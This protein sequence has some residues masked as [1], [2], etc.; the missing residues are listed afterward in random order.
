M[1]LSFRTLISGSEEL[2]PAAGEEI[3]DWAQRAALEKARTS[4]RSLT[5]TEPALIL[6]ADTVVVLPVASD[7]HVPLLHGNPAQILGK[8]GTPEI[9]RDMLARLSG[10]SHIVVS[11]FALLTHPAG[12]SITDVVET[13]VQFTLLSEEE[14]TRYI[15]SG[16]PLD[17]AGAYGIQGLGAV[18]I[19]SIEGDYYTV[20]GLPLARLWQRLQ[21]WRSA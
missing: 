5:S 20:V 16:E 8:P 10:T 15:S 3:L 18:F 13:R 11:A 7:A 4:A 1:G 2:P 19:E 6:G 9:A 14:I 12:E 21:P 17:K